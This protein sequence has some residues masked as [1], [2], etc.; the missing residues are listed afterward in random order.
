MKLIYKLII[1]R[2][3]KKVQLYKIHFK[4]IS[5]TNIKLG[6]IIITITEPIENGT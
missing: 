3:I 4:L 1:Q 5:S 2:D 6:N